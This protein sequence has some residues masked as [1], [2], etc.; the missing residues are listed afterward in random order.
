MIYVTSLRYDIIIIT[1]IKTII[2][3]S[4]FLSKIRFNLVHKFMKVHH[5]F[6]SFC[7]MKHHQ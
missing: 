4:S 7:E 6:E 5:Y 1:L 3:F 2:F